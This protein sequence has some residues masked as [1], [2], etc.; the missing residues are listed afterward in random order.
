MHTKLF[1]VNACVWVRVR[2][3]VRVGVID[4]GECKDKC[5]GIYGL[6]RIDNKGTQLLI[7]FKNQ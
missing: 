5:V 7:F 6:E 4:D 1:I 2:V 3:R